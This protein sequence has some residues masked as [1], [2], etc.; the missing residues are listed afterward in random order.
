MITGLSQMKCGGCGGE[1]F[2]V[3]TADPTVE[4]IVECQQCKSTS[5]I[6]VS[7]PKLVI[8]WGEASTGVLAVFTKS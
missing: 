5:T 4:I 7:T 6:K 3:F 1:Q 8:G 2:K